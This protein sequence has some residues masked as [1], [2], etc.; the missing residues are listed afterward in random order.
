VLVPGGRIS[1]LPRTGAA[2]T[3]RLRAGKKYLAKPR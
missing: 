3:L 2:P 1:T